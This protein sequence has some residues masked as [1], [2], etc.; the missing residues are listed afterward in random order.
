MV[1]RASISLFVV[2][3]LVA[4]LTG[5]AEYSLAQGDATPAAQGQTLFTAPGVQ[6]NVLASGDATN[7]GIANPH[8]LLERLTVPNGASTG[9]HTTAGPELLYV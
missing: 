6:T 8:L 3:L 2:V 5:A 4:S 1:R 9:L 7:V